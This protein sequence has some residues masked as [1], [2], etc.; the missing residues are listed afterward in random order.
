MVNDQDLARAI[1]DQGFRLVSDLVAQQDGDDLF[2]E[3]GGE[4]GGF[5][6]ELIADLLHSAVALF[7]DNKNILTHCFAPSHQMM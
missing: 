3:I 1:L 6:D 5:A 4:L 2:T 7:N